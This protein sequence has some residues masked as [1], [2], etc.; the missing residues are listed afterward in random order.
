GGREER[1]GGIARNTL[2][3]TFG[4]ISVAVAILLIAIFTHNF[5]F[6]YVA[7]ETSLDMTA[8]YLFSAWWAGNSGSL[9]FWAWVLGLFAVILSLRKRAIGQELIPYASAIIMITEAFFLLLLVS[10]GNPFHKLPVPPADGA[11]MNPLL[12]NPGMIF[13]PPALLAGYA[14]FAIPFAI[15]IAALLT[16]KLD[17]D[18]TIAVRR[19]T[20]LPWLL[21]GVGNIIGAWWAYVELGWGGYWA[22]DPVEN[23]GLIPW[24][25]ATAFL[26][27]TMVQRRKGMFKVWNMVLIILAFTLAIFGTFLT[28]SNILSSVHT[29]G[30]LGLEPFF[31]T[32]LAVTFF[33]S[34]ALVFMRWNE[35][36]SE[37]EVDS[38]ASR[39]STFLVNNLLLVGSALA[40]FL[41]TM[42]PAISQLFG[43]NKIEVGKAFF[44][45]VNGPIFL[46]I[47]LLAGICVLIGW[48]PKPV[49]ELG[50]KLLWPLVVA[51]VVGAGLFAAGVR[52]F[53]AIGVFVVCTFVLF[54]ILY[55]WS[56]ETRERHQARGEDYFS[57][58]F[59]LLRGNRTRYGG[60]IVHI[61]VI[62]M[63]IGVAGSSVYGIQKDAALKQ[64]E[65]MTI[66]RYTLTY[67]DMGHTTTDTTLYTTLTVTANVSVQ[68]A[69]KSI[70]TVTPQKQ[71]KLDNNYNLVSDP[72]SEVAIRSTPREDLY[73]ILLGADQSGSVGFRALVNPLVAW[74][75]VGGWLFLLGGLIAFWPARRR[76]AVVAEGEP[77][78]VGETGNVKSFAGA[79][80]HFCPECGAKHAEG[81]RFCPH[82]G[83]KL[84]G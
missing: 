7:S 53:T 47:I 3:G 67:N 2:L 24:L 49:K 1:G 65:S 14:G 75:W 23:A 39:E 18:W 60:Y 12:L 20:L 52:E 66:G 33:G 37:V 40:I 50:R 6:E 61:A 74:I 63:A 5:S 62:L 36:K 80:R 42:F 34:L 71:F 55:Q 78:A 48:Q 73:V 57:A 41:G 59:S 64:G 81:D 8:P 46:A 72:V 54:S 43:G 82:C 17:K 45:M 44:N 83:S 29:F 19:W 26:H 70:G 16:G 58:F 25:V 15:A 28:R 76:Y 79:R 35:L 38:L 30:D 9:L 31:T 77:E 22:W 21:L 84:N 68:N 4:L 10:V 51:L 69:G 56:R 27:S 11:G 13:H 32:F